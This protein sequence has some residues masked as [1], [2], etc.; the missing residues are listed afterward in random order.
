MTTFTAPDGK[1]SLEIGRYLAQHYASVGEFAD[2]Y[3]QEILKLNPGWNHFE[4]K[5]ARG[6]LSDT[7]HAV[8]ITS[9]RRNDTGDCTED[10]ITHLI[11]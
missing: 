8:I 2:E 9:D 11:R 3:R 4:E 5:S 6:E 1:H 7:G 10:G